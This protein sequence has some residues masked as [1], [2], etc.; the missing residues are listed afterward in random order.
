MTSNNSVADRVRGIV[1]TVDGHLLLIKRIRPGVEPYWVFPGGGVEA[2]DV[3]RVEALRREI[4]EELGCDAVIGNLVY[5]LTRNAGT[6][7]ASRE[8]YFIVHIERHDL[9]QRNGPEFVSATSGEYVYDTFPLND[10]ALATRN[11]KP[12]AMKQFLLT[13]WR[14]FDALPALTEA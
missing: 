14:D 3:S 2:T 5:I 1:F 7:E 12:D 10:R 13:N 8:L 11:I 9:S 4:R 6:S